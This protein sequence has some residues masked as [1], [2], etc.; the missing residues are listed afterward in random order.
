DAA[1]LDEQRRSRRFRRGG[2]AKQDQLAVVAGEIPLRCF[3]AR[4]QL[5]LA[6]DFG[7]DPVRLLAEFAGLFALRGKQQQP[8]A[9]GNRNHDGYG[10]G[11][12]RRL[13]HLQPVVS[14]VASELAV[15]PEPDSVDSSL[16][17]ELSPSSS[18]ASP[19]EDS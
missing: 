16:G 12:L 13:L 18:P 10:E 4:N 15:S 6:R 17:S 14:A 8:E 7:A 1:Q 9:G 11:S 5:L 19:A 2:L 3:G